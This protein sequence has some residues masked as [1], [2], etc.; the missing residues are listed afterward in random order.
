MIKEPLPSDQTD[1][2]NEESIYLP[3]WEISESKPL[4]VCCLLARHSALFG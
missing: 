1:W 2:P 4:D 3:F